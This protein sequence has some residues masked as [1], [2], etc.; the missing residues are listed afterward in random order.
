MQQ[1]LEVETHLEDYRDEVKGN[2]KKARVGRAELGSEPCALN[3]QQLGRCHDQ[4]REEQN[5]Q[6]NLNRSWA[7][8]KRC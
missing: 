3:L 7:I 2:V 6:R 5:Y 1:L 4:K 8:R